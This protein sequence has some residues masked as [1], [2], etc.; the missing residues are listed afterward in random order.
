MNNLKEAQELVAS[1]G[2]TPTLDLSSASNELDLSSAAEA[3]PLTAGRLLGAFAYTVRQ[4]P[5]VMAST[6]KSYRKFAASRFQ[7]VESMDEP[8][9]PFVADYRQAQGL[10]AGRTVFDEHFDR[11]PR[12]ARIRPDG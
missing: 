7:D 3:T 8:L 5:G 9:D 6:L 4:T 2:E 11:L 10:D 1:F 12:E